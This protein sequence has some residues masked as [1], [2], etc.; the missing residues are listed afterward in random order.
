MHFCVGPDF[1]IITMLATLT[2]LVPLLGTWLVWGLS[3]W[4]A[5]HDG[6][7]VR[8]G[9]LALYGSVF[10]GLLDNVIR[11][12]VL[13]SNVKLHPLLA[14]VSVMG[15]FQ[16]MGLWGVFVGPGRR[17]VPACPVRSSTPNCSSAGATDGVASRSTGPRP[18]PHGV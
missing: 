14:F 13:H 16:L 12:Y 1:F 2:A 10:V 8:A 11:S 7:W 18:F 6:D 4:L 15:G 3:L 17:F 9:L 5:F